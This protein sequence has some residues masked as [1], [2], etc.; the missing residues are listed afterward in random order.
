MKD[1]K[2]LLYAVGLLLVLGIFALLAQGATT[3]NGSKSNNYRVAP[4]VPN[5]VYS[6]K[7]V[8][9]NS[10]V[11]IAEPVVNGNYVTAINVHN[12]QITTV[13]LKKKAVIALREGNWGNVSNKIDFAIGPDQ[14]FYIDCPDIGGILNSSGI[15]M[16]SFADGFVEIESPQE[17]DVVGVITAGGANVESIDV[18]T[19]NPKAI[20]PCGETNLTL[21]TGQGV[22]TDPY[23][24]IAP[25]FATTPD[26][27]VVTSATA[28]GQWSPPLP[29]SRWI[30][31]RANAASSTSLPQN[32]TYVLN[33]D[34]PPCFSN[35]ILNLSGRVDDES[36]VYLNGK[37]IGQLF[38]SPIGS[39]L[40]PVTD[41]TPSDFV[42]GTNTLTVKVR[43]DNPP[44][45]GLDIAGT[46]TAS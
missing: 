17:L 36:W 21:N 11:R 44:I 29:G 31:W 34:L 33:F 13:N 15:V 41:T 2:K 45:T 16:P 20:I 12:P 1:K 38:N 42:S 24:A 28:L 5:F 43:D 14:A 9:G 3:I 19:I 26:A 4:P 30:S 18:E 46:V 35:P 6:A 25:P 32:Y 39:N 23:W 40:I 22:L 10:S 8:C 37:F 7:F 27:F